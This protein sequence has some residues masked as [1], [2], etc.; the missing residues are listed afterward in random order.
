MD[1]IL[2]PWAPVG[3]K[4]EIL[5]LEMEMELRMIIEIENLYLQPFT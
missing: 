5:F 4:K 3:A 1:K 2:T